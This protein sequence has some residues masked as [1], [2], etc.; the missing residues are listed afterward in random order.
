MVRIGMEIVVFLVEMDKYGIK[1]RTNALALKIQIGM[2]LY[3]LLAHQGKYGI[4]DF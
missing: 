2:D 4:I 1:H 3:V